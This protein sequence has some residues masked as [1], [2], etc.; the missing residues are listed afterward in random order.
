MPIEMMAIKGGQ[1]DYSFKQEIIQVFL[2]I[3][4]PDA[5]LPRARLIV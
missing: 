4:N 2:F 1:M 3:I 5:P